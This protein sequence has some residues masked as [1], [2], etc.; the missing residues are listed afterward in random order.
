MHR[1]IEKA[2][3]TFEEMATVLYEIEAILISRPLIALDADSNDLAYLSPGHFL[4]GITMNVPSCHDLDDVS[5]NR[6]V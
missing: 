5:E 2:H 4:I 6:L 3:L 1:V